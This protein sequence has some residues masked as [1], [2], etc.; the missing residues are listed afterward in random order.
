MLVVLGHQV[1]TSR[2]NVSFDS[3]LLNLLEFQRY[4]VQIFFILSGFLITTLLKNEEESR[5]KINV[6]DF[7][8]RRIFRIAPAYYVFLIVAFALYEF[9]FPLDA[10]PRHFL[11]ASLFLFDFPFWGLPQSL[12]HAW[13]LGVEMQFYFLWTLLYRMKKKFVIPVILIC[14][15]PVMRVIS[16]MYPQENLHVTFFANVDFI[17]I[18]T[19]FAHY[20]DK[21]IFQ[22]LVSKAW[23]IWSITIALIIMERFSIPKTA[24]LTVP[25][26]K[27][28]FAFSAVLLIYYSLYSSTLLYKFF[29]SRVLVFLGTISYSI[30]LW[31]QIFYYYGCGIGNSIITTFP[32]NWACI[33]L[34]AWLSYHFIEKPFMNNR[35]RIISFLIPGKQAQAKQA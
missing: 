7:Y 6:L 22:K 25:F 35:K 34:V 33:I 8:S 16:H 15:G 24:I 5:G 12:S 17:F 13:S 3:P 31:Q 32:I 1:G 14:F 9:G 11:K 19:L 4:G 2:H 28:F 29:N 21:P 26:M 27:T 20:I 18:G 30:Y 10:E 23:W